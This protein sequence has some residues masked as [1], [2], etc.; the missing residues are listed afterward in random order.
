MDA[1]LQPQWGARAQPRATPWVN[2]EPILAWSPI[3]AK[4][5]VRVQSHTYRSNSIPWILNNRPYPS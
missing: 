4:Y 5:E 1:C 3:R 2:R